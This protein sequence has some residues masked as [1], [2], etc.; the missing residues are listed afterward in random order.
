MVW[1]ED[2]IVGL[3][4]GPKGPWVREKFGPRQGPGP[5]KGTPAQLHF[6]SVIQSPNPP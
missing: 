1:V 5:I 4:P 3:W 6:P 2:G